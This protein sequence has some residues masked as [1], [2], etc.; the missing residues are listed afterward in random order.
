MKHIGIVA[1]SAEG[2]ALCY[3]SICREALT[4]VG[5]NDHP[6]ITLDSIPMA[7]WMPA[8]DA[9]DYAGVARFMLDSARL[10]AAAGADFAIC[11]DNSAHLAWD[12]VQAETP[13][14]WLH[15]ARVVGEEAGRRGFRRLGILGTRFTMG[16]GA[17]I[18]RPVLDSLGIETIVPDASDAEKVDRIIF[19]ELVDGVFADSSRQFYNEVITRLA[20]RGCDAVALACTEIPLLVR[21]EEVSLPTLDSTRLLAKAALREALD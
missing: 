21:P 1:C 10:L 12:H 19:A 3:Q 8:F 15:I 6:R 18:Y 20:E 5:K 9:G 13:I 14:P 17:P 16:R 2:A 11:P 4:V 7:R